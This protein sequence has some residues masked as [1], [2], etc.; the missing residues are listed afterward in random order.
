MDLAS[1]NFFERARISALRC[2]RRNSAMQDLDELT[3]DEMILAF[4]REDAQSN[5]WRYA[6]EKAPHWHC[7]TALL[8]YPDLNNPED[9]LARRQMLG[10][11]R[12]YGQNKYLFSGFPQSV[13][14]RR[15]QASIDELGSA[16]YILQEKWKK[17]SGKTRYV[18][19][20]ARCVGRH[21]DAGD[22][23][24][25]EIIQKVQAISERLRRGDR[26]GPVIAVRGDPGSEL[27]LLDGHHRLPGSRFALADDALRGRAPAHSSPAYGRVGWRQI[28]AP[29]RR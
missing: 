11:A 16:K 2:G 15:H 14:W 6:Y 7:R 23:Q 1:H 8:E 21:I 20:G 3:E 29:E 9:N 18:R 19:D 13:E 12:G 22:E 25:A 24:V 26:F 28:T 10:T 5:T 27:V 4:L 17:L